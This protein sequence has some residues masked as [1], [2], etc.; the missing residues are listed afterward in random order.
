MW[1]GVQ[2]FACAGFK[3]GGID[4]SPPPAVACIRGQ[5]RICASTAQARRLSAHHKGLLDDI[6]P[7]SQYL[8][9]AMKRALTLKG[10]LGTVVLL[11]LPGVVAMFWTL[12]QMEQAAQARRDSGDVLTDANQFLSNLNDAESGQRGYLL[13]GDASYL[14]QYTHTVGKLPLEMATLRKRP[15]EATALVRLD[16][17]A[18]L[19]ESKLQ[20]LAQ[21]IT[22]R[23]QHDLQTAM[24][25][26][27]TGRGKDLMDALR[28]EMAAFLRIEEAAFQQYDE[29]YRG[30][31]RT[32]YLG[33]VLSSVL[34]LLYALVFSQTALRN[35]R[36]RLG[37]LL[38]LETQGRLAE[39]SAANAQLH[40]VEV[41]LRQN[42]AL[43]SAIF[44]SANFSSIATDARGVIQ[45]FNVGAERMLG[46]DAQEVMNKITPAEISD[47]EEIMAR[48]QTLST[49]LG[50]E[51]QPGFEALVFKATR[52]IEDIYEL[53]YIRKDG[54]RFPAVVSVT[55]LRDADNAIIGYLLIGTDNT[56]RKAVEA[57]RTRLDQ[58]LLDKNVELQLARVEADKANQAKSDFLS[59]MSHELRSPLNAI[60]GFAQLMESASPEPSTEQKASIDQILRAGWY[61]LELINEVLDLALIESGKLSLS[62]E[63]M[64]LSEVFDDC[65]T[66]IEPLAAKRNISLQFPPPKG[67]LFVQG[68][69][70]RVKQVLIN[71]LSNAIKYNREGGTV[72]VTC[73]EAVGA[74]LRICVQ[75]SG[76]G[77]S[78][79]KIAQLFQPFNRLGQEASA[80]EGTGIGL[81]VSK[82]LVE[83]MGGEIG[84]SSQV[85]VGSVFWIELALSDASQLT[86]ENTL[87]LQ[88]PIGIV[89]DGV[90]TR[91]LLYVEDNRA[92]M[93]L[94]EQLVARRPGMR[95]LGAADG[96][97]GI[98]LARLHLPDLILM[99]INL[100][101]ISGLQA[102]KILRD[103]P[104]TCHIPVLALSAN[105]LPRDVA[106]GMEAGFFRYLTKPV[107]VAEF[108]E[109]LD[110][111]LILAD[112]HHG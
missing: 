75:D 18:P 81:V 51:I 61:L 53:T 33:V 85:G 56:A 37:H 107:K 14:L 72:Q 80:G 17:T 87:G 19:L 77:L 32:M 2:K 35:E 82:R 93:E 96:M 10:V 5:G 27:S 16:A 103:D 38:Q 63:P 22:A 21:S 50:V 42:A 52:G 15:L 100:P 67:A 78:L 45:I 55:A 64:S 60:L 49:E 83:L 108:M 89:P 68:D 23:Q 4:K 105:A 43:Q 90:H 84:M 97:R 3:L 26:V 47:R 110:M 28:T 41:A 48:A 95:L 36:Q 25:I 101:G 20:E 7:F 91:T 40:H 69:R 6:P 31:V 24:R 59:S 46:Y 66:L 13:T 30:A 29:N 109:A 112:T 86:Q 88:A 92:N 58:V 106:R 71:L 94:V 8:A 65:H 57:E 1:A 12:H 99:D 9:V 104:A 76:E 102:L 39:Q 34:A 62:I 11:V 73:H 44:N 54:S 98:L 74:R 111:G 70:T 79:D